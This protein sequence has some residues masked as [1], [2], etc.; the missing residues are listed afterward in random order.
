[1]LLGDLLDG[2]GYAP[3]H[4]LASA[5]AR[6]AGPAALEATARLVKI[7][8]SSGWDL[9]AGFLGALGALPRP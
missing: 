9:L 8:H 3:L 6:C 7:G 1:V 4:D 5:L 2:A